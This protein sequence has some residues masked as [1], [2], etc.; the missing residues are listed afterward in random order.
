MMEM[1]RKLELESRM[2]CVEWS[3]GGRIMMV[4]KDKRR[5]DCDG[6]GVGICEEGWR[7]RYGCVCAKTVVEESRNCAVWI[8]S[9]FVN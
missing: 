4:T 9:G 3:R 7:C 8:R 5:E 6:V 2:Q 1:M